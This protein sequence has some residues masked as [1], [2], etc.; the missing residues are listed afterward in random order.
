MNWIA[1]DPRSYGGA[2]LGA[3]AGVLAFGTLLQHGWNLPWIVGLLMGLGCALVTQERSSMRGVV[4]AIGAAWVSAAAQ[5]YYA[6]PAGTDGMIA[7]HVQFHTTLSGP[8]LL[9]NLGSMLAALLFGRSA[10][11]RGARTRLAG[12]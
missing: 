1:W 6:P 3:G 9:A 11:R 7:G 4:L 5:V 2:L 8:T 10:L 12:A